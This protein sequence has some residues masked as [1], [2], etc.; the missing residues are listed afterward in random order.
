M[1]KWFIRP[2]VLLTLLVVRVNVAAQSTTRLEIAYVSDSDN[3]AARATIYVTDRFGNARQPISNQQTPEMLPSWAPDGRSLMYMGVQGGLANL[4]ANDVVS[5]QTR[6]VTQHQGNELYFA[7][8]WSPLGDRVVCVR[9][10][11]G[12]RGYGVFLLDV[13]TGDVGER[14]LYNP[15]PNDA[16]RMNHAVDWSVNDEI[17]AS[18]ADGGF[19]LYRLS[20]NGNETLR[21]TTHPRGDHHPSWS[22]DGE[23]VLFHSDRDGRWQIYRVDREGNTVSR[24]TDVPFEVYEPSWSPDGR[25]ALCVSN[26]DGID[27]IY[28]LDVKTGELGL[29]LESDFGV[30]Q[31]R[32]YRPPLS[33][34]A[35][36]M[37]LSTWGWLRRA[38]SARR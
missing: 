17:A 1:F 35:E 27:K 18:F 20:P 16:P 38:G 4:F 23:T 34:S 3:P 11:L 29:F 36:K 15:D 8:A 33:V 14:L 32:W 7:S 2:V 19:D 13:E 25:T 24:V 22:P 21:L 31:P 6:Q 26:R 28:T 12:N 9:N 10:L 37:F 5:R 30:F